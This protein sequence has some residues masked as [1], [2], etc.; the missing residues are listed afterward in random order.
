MFEEGWQLLGARNERTRET[1]ECS[2]NG[3]CEKVCE[4][5]YFEG[6]EKNSL[7]TYFPHSLGT[8]KE[9][10][11]LKEVLCDG[12]ETPL[13]DHI[14]CVTCAGSGTPLKGLWPRG[15]PCQSRRAA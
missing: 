11:P 2:Q 14:L 6:G 1:Q 12:Q 7:F 15:N 10:N 8:C 4:E 9:T 13:R 5:E 3:T